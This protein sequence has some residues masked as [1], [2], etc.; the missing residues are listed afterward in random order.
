MS[1][2][3]VPFAIP[4]VFRIGPFAITETV[5][6]TWGIMVLLVAFAALARVSSIHAKK[7]VLATLEQL[8]EAVE[9]NIRAVIP[10]RGGAAV[11]PFIATLWVFI[12]IS[13]LSGVIPGLRSPTSDLSTTAA[14]AL[15]VFLYTHWFAVRYY[16]WRRYLRHY[17]DPSPLLT[18]F[19]I[20]SEFSRSLTLAIR[21]YGNMMSLQLAAAIVIVLAGLLVPV[22]LLMLHVLEAVIQA[23]I[24]G[25]LA[26][27]YVAGSVASQDVHDRQKAG[28]L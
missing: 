7:G 12:A 27:V 14:L 21:L 23:Y 24:F 3:Q 9:A 25:M 1:A 28:S 10:E 15:L 17:I 18:P 13:N 22:P 8:Y 5:V 20:I 11:L 4:T 6:V 26:L 16:G 2:A 19:Q